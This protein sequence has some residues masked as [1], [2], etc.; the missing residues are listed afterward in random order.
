MLSEEKVHDTGDKRAEEKS[1]IQKSEG[2]P[3]DI[4]VGQRNLEDI[5]ASDNVIT[6]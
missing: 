2:L 6:V 1:V 5:S 3:R 4:K